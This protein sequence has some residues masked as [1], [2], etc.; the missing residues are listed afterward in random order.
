MISYWFIFC[1][2]IDQYR[3]QQKASQQLRELL[4]KPTASRRRD[5]PVW[6]IGTV[7]ASVLLSWGGYRYWEVSQQ[8]QLLET[9]L[10]NGWQETVEATDAYHTSSPEA[11][12]LLL[13]PQPN[14]DQP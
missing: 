9:F 10:V 12:W 5:L 1:G 8:E 4:E 11:E 13:A 14:S 2:A 6:V 3:R 7:T